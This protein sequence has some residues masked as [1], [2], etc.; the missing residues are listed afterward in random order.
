MSSP[1]TLENSLI[2]ACVRTEPERI[3]ELVEL[4]RMAGDRPGLSSGAWCHRSN[5][6]SVPRGCRREQAGGSGPI[7]ALRT[8]RPDGAITITH[9]SKITQLAKYQ[10]HFRDR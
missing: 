10:P 6:K 9:F 2:L 4:P 7:R 5:D 3:R 8:C 1:L